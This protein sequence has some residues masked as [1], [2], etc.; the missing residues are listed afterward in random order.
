MLYAVLE[1]AERAVVKVEEH[2]HTIAL[3]VAACPIIIAVLAVA[4]E[5]TIVRADEPAVGA[6]P[7]EVFF[8]RVEVRPADANHYA[9]YIPYQ[10]H[11]P[12]V[13]AFC[14]LNPSCRE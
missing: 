12:I 4:K 7:I 1:E 6:V 13:L 9:A 14:E 11:L 8:C 10:R 2:T 5:E 3:L